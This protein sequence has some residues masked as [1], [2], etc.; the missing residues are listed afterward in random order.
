[1]DDNLIIRQL[2]DRNESVL[3]EISAKYSRLYLGIL[4]QVLSNEQD[5]A[6]C[7]NDVLLAIWNTVPPNR[8][9]SLPAYVCR[10]ARNIG[11]DRLRYETRQKRNCGYTVALS[12]LEECLTGKVP[13]RSQDSALI[14][15]VLSRF[16]RNLDPETQVLFVRRYIYLESVSDLARRFSLPENRVAV[17]LY[18]ARKQLKRTLEK[19]GI[20]L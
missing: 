19:E 16:V 20:T 15:E 4:G 10:I 14:Q 5:I 13:D 1:M 17:R 6:E 9:H 3:N 11:I 12:E 18:R 7:A 2:F 8:P